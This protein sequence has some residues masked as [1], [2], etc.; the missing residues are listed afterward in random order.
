MF[1]TTTI[2]VDSPP[3]LQIE[4]AHGGIALQNLELEVLAGNDAILSQHV[5]NR[6]ARQLGVVVLLAEVAEPDVLQALSH[7]LGHSCGTVGIAEV[8]VLAE[9]AC[10]E[11]GGIG[12][13]LEHLDVVVG[14]D[15]QI[16]GLADEGFHRIGDA[17]GIGD[18]AEV[19]IVDTDHEADV[20]AGVMRHGERGNVETAQ[21]EGL[22][23]NNLF[24]HRRVELALNT[25]VAIDAL[26]NKLGGIDGQVVFVA[27]AANRLDVVGVVVGNKHIA[28]LTKAETIVG[29]LFLQCA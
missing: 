13:V 24:L 26:M 2:I 15:D 22:A 3:L 12:S 21:R 19:D 9:N 27:D 6:L 5:L 17:A 10:L 23:S 11:I 16:V 7:V 20:L 29:K 25:V 18:E 8:T 14:L 28:N 4:D 1:S